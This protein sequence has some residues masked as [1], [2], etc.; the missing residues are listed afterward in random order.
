MLTEKD[1]PFIQALNKLLD[2]ATFPVKRREGAAFISVCR[3]AEGLE[4]KITPEPQK[5]SK[6]KVS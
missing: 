1:R 5:K 3:W 2:E 4:K 6:K